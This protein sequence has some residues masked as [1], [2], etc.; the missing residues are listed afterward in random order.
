MLVIRLMNIVMLVA[1]LG[2]TAGCQVTDDYVPTGATGGADTARRGQLVVGI[3]PDSAPMCFN[4][5]GQIKGIEADFARMLA[6]ELGLKPVFVGLPFSDLRGELSAGRIDIIM[7]GMSVTEARR[8]MVDFTEPYT[9]IGQCV[10]VR[11]D[12]F[13]QLGA[14]AAIDHADTRIAVENGTTG[15]AYARSTFRE[16]R[17][18]ALP[19]LDDAI[20]HLRV[21]K[22]DALIHDSAILQWRAKHRPDTFAMVPGERTTEPIAWAIRKGNTRLKNRVNDILAQW[23]RD[24]VVEEVLN[25]WLGE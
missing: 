25:R 1:L 13:D 19:S 22:V 18:Y 9:T 7:A 6:K 16:A 8:R 5:G 4:D 21:G 2:L 3:D 12:R 14:W 15:E 11:R 20:A 17:V 23:K 10:M 24:G